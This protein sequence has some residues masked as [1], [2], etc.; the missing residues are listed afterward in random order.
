MRSARNDDWSDRELLGVVQDAVDEDGSG[1]ATTTEIGLKMGF[2]SGEKN[3]TAATKV[4]SRLAYMRDGGLLESS[5]RGRDD[6]YYQPGDH[7]LRWSLTQAGH[8]VLRGKLTKTVQS[9]LD[10][11][12]PGDKVM[13]LKEVMRSG[14]IEGSDTEAFV[15]DRQIKHDRSQVRHVFRQVRR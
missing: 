14:W 4:G 3:Q 10:R 15:I 7:D 6:P 13:L 1:S 5:R 9:A 2:T 11:M 8:A 12:G